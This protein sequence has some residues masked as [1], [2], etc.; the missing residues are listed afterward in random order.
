MDPSILINYVYPNELAEPVLW[1]P[2]MF[3]YAFLISGADLLMLASIGFITGKI[4]RAI[5]LLTLLGMSFFS[6]I[7]LGPLADLRQPQRAGLILT[8]LHIFPSDKYPGVS[9]ISLYGGVLW[10]TT[11]IVGLLF[12]LLYF[13][14]PM[15]IKASRNGTL[16]PLYNLLSFGIRSE[17]TYQK[18]SPLLK[19][20]AGVLFIFATLWG[21]YPSIL[22]TSQTWLFIWRNWPILPVIYFADTFVT[23]TAAAILVY[24]LWKFD[25]MD[26]EYVNP[27]LKIHFTG[28]LAVAGLLILQVSIWGWWLGGSDF[29]SSFNIVIPLVIAVI[30]L[31]IISAIISTFSLR[32][33][34]LS[35]LV[36][37]VALI[38][39]LINKW[40]IMINGQ[41]V[42]RTGL[43]VLEL[44]L[45]HGWFLN[46][47]SPISLAVVIFILITWLFPL[48]VE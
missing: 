41:L 2:V 17:D 24:F 5:P 10:I 30:F 9:T 37:I 40:N 4:K 47:I 45:P 26:K 31:M 16:R 19:V 13:S 39:V 27:L 1:L 3:A 12:M 34:Q 43:G 7:L 42:S 33:S 46:M 25:K 6:V 20:I 22:L 18:L 44:T 14:Y 35:I 21:L 36:S 38:G 11:F 28:C 48:E 32:W 29:Y 15:Y 8:N 23:S